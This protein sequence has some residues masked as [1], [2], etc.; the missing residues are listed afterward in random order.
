MLCIGS[1]IYINRVTGRGYIN[2][3]LKRSE[4]EILRT[5]VAII[6]YSV[7]VYVACG[8]VIVHVVST[9][10]CDARLVV[11]GSQWVVIT[12]GFIHAPQ[13]RRREAEFNL[14]RTQRGTVCT[15]V[16]DVEVH[17]NDSVGG[18][19][20]DQYFLVGVVARRSQW[21]NAGGYEPKT[22]CC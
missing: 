21:R 22:A 12:S 15:T 5:G 3:I 19:L 11:Y 14:T 6:P 18:E 13:N 2:G 10:Y 17:V 7:G 16:L 9:A 8:S 20:S 4:W 1:G